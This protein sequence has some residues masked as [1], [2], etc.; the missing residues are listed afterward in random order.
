[1]A[2]QRVRVV[3]TCT[4]RKRR[5]TPDALRLRQISG[6]HISTRFRAWTD[7]LMK[8][9][10]PVSQ[11]I[12]L[13]AGEYWSIVRRLSNTVIPVET[14]ICSAGYGLISSDSPIRPYSATF[15]TGSPDSIPDGSR[16]ASSWWKALSDWVGPSPGPRSITDLVM[17][18][19]EARIILVLS[20]AYLKACRQDIVQA[21]NQIHQDG[22]LSIISA[23][24]KE[25]PQ[26]APYLLPGD[27]RF[28]SALGGTRQT[29]NIRAAQYLLAT[30]V[31]KHDEMVAT[32]ARLLVDQPSIT[33]YKRRTATD[34]EVRTFIQ[35]RLKTDPGATHTRLLRQFR[36]DDRACEQNRFT[37]LFHIEA[38]T[39][40]GAAR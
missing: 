31:I 14:W 22:Q 30:G 39:R 16:G 18:D 17:A 12:D 3:V 33:R 26:L 13:Y 27:A 23:G 8:S 21:L 20:A 24:T 35:D 1:M 4:H 7:R 2:N 38:R 37:A 28:Q 6:A 11:A 25:D 34:A 10:E 5:P 19:P 15:A 40:K 32:L 9:S 36:D 29:L